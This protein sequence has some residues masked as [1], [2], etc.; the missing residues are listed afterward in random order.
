MRVQVRSKQRAATAYTLASHSPLE[1][2]TETVDENHM[3]VIDSCCPCRGAASS[4]GKQPASKP[5]GRE[6]GGNIREE[7]LCTTCNRPI[8]LPARV[9]CS[10]AHNSAQAIINFRGNAQQP[11]GKKLHAHHH[12][13]V[14]TLHVDVVANTPLSCQTKLF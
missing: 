8:R 10:T 3:V 9:E 13:T 11:P 6:A 7:A 12:A 14:S 4:L 5:K 2:R 1:I